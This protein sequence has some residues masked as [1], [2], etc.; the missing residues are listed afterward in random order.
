VPLLLRLVCVLLLLLVLMR[1]ILV[2]W[3]KYP[4]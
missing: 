2:G 3:L 1:V 4:L